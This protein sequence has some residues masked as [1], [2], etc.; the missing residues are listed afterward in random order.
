MDDLGLLLEELLDVRTQWY[1]LGALLKL[2]VGTL[3]M[4]G[5]EFPNPRDRLLEMLKT[6]L[7]TAVNPSWNTLTNALRSRN[8]GA[9]LLADIYEAKYCLTELATS[10]SD[11]QPETNVPPPSPEQVLPTPQPLMVNTHKGKY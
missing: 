6:W 7:R 11:S 5:R 2:S 9:S 1:S 4:I 10:T 8:V 3:D